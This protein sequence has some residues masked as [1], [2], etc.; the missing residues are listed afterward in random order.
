MTAHEFT[1]HLWEAGFNRN[2]MQGEKYYFSL[3]PLNFCTP[4]AIGYACWWRRQ[5]LANNAAC[6]GLFPLKTGTRL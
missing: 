3:A 2:L 1:F 6:T 4:W 5:I